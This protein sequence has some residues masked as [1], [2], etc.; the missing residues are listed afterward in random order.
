MKRVRFAICGSMVFSVV[1]F[2]LFLNVCSA[3]D[4]GKQK[5]P[6]E[7]LKSHMEQCT[8]KYGFDPDKTQGLGERELGKGEEDWRS[9]VYEG[10]R[11]LVAPAS[12]VPKLYADLIEQDRGLTESIKKGEMTRSER[13]QKNVA[14][15]EEIKRQEEAKKAEQLKQ[16][17]KDMDE[18]MRKKMEL[19][20]RRG[21]SPM[22][23][24]DSLMR[25]MGR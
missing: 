10:I 18:V 9:C 5:A 12:A 11:K 22:H 13:K 20:M 15:I 6:E 3:A 17:Q 1:V 23:A 21:G 16:K 4:K 14:L 2:F 7:A 25:G 19:D 24:Q 8:A